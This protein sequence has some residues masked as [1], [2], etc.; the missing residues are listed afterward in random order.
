MIDVEFLLLNCRAPPLLYMRHITE[1][2]LEIS[3]QWSSL[4]IGDREKLT[5]ENYFPT[6]VWAPRDFPYSIYTEG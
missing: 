4:P 2:G 5:D 6:L 1:N 3:I